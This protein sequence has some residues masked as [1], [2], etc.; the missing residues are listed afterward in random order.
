[1]SNGSRSETRTAFALTE[2]NDKTYWTKIGIAYVNKDGSLTCKLDALP[3]SG[4]LQI[5]SE[6]TSR[7][8]EE[9]R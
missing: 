3:V 1:M 4:T 9:R 5:R 7:N 6:D 2:R 8:G